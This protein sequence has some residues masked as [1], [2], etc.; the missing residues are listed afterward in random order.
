M[1]IF[2]KDKWLTKIFKKN[3]YQLKYCDYEDSD[4]IREWKSFKGHKKN[5]KFFIF[6]KITTDNITVWKSLEKEGF[7]LID[8]NIKLR[9]DS[10]K[11]E[12]IFN[13]EQIKTSFAKQKHKS[14]IGEIAKNN[15]IYSRF[16]IDPLID[17]D[18]ANQ[19]KQEWVENYFDG[20]RGDKMIT[21]LK[22]N[23]PVGF[24][25]L[26]I[27]GE[28]LLIDLIGV[29]K[30]VQGKGVATGMIYYA[31]DN[32]QHSF[33]KVGTQIGNIP[34][35]KLYQNLGF[36]ISSSEYIFHYHSK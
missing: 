13:H 4:F 20:K 2:I 14:A 29:D 34:S 12:K 6:F 28:E 18:I 19:I 1:K 17:N 27:S 31:M 30:S 3:V 10:R 23:K 7:T 9:L 5:E 35:I 33:M 32:I 24:L 11:S 8:T 15:F 16:H 21:A 26:I 22:D 25:Q 36:C